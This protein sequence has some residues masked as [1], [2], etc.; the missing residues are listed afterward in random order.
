MKSKIIVG[1]I[2]LTVFLLWTAAVCIVDVRPIGPNDSSVG[3]A[4]INGYVHDLTGVNYGLYIITDWLSLIP[5]AMVMGFGFLGLKQWIQRKSIWKVDGSILALGIFYLV[6]GA[7]FLFFENVVINYR[8]VLI[9]G[10]LE[11]S[12]PSSTTM[13]VLC[14][15]GSAGF[16]FHQRIQNPVLRWCVILAV[17]AFTVLMVAGRLLSGVHWLTDIIGGGLLSGGLLILYD[18]A[19]KE[20]QIYN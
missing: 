2:L 19:A 8:P 11:A 13:L 16:R 20:W 17:S 1:C 18:A 3:F 5:V 4:M 7:M 9:E 6:V 12:Y 14:V 15:M 10:V